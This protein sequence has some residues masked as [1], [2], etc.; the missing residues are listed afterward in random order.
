[1]RAGSGVGDGPSGRFRPGRSRERVRRT[2]PLTGRFKAAAL[3][4]ALLVLI[5]ISGGCL[6]KESGELKVGE[7]SRERISRF[8][9][10]TGVLEP[11]D[12]VYVF[13]PVDATIA[14]LEVKDGDFVEAGRILARLDE[15]KLREALAS[16]R[17]RYLAAGSLGDA[18]AAQY[19]LAGAIGQ[20]LESIS[21]YFVQLAREMGSVARTVAEAVPLL[22]SYL[23][24]EARED[25]R[26]V[27]EN[28]RREL[29][30]LANIDLPRASIQ[31]PGMP[32]SVSGASSASKEAAG[33][34]LK[35]LSDALRKPYL[36]SPVAGHVVFL[37][38]SAGLPSQ[39]LGSLGSLGG[40]ASMLSS[41]AGFAGIDLGGLFEGTGGGELREGSKV[42]AGSPVF[43]VVD[44]REMRVKVQVEEADALLVRKGQEV[45]V[46]LDAL[47]GKTFTGRVESVG[48][49][50][51]KG[52]SG[53]TV[54]PVYVRLDRTEEDLR[55]GLNA[56][57][58]LQVESREQAVVIPLSAVVESDGRSFVYVVSEGK[59]VLREVV[60]GIREKEMVEVISGLEEGEL[61]V[62]EDVR[63]VK[64][65]MRVR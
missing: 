1:M 8:V 27:Y 3:V 65:G 48:V 25:A 16:A 12:P 47:P 37:Q 44:L 58:D 45:R 13:S 22:V 19:R 21:G 33:Y 43:Q 28:L 56:T 54:F 34:E 30:E 5:A 17:A 29:D 23:P 18:I 41:F 15:E 39:L 14:S 49:K 31:V 50:A 63:R 7:A 11:A 40:I 61:V 59:A 57:V 51:E 32:S 52:S 60:L 2:G 64:E 9:S 42:A 24:P 53:N 36:S 62:V 6:H 4:A 10:A 26:L 38:P 46:Y 20:G 55:I 35:R